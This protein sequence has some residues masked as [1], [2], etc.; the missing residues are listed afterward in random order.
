METPRKQPKK[1]VRKSVLMAANTNEQL[2]E[3]LKDVR[4]IRTKIVNR[5]KK[6]EDLNRKIKELYENYEWWKIDYDELVDNEID[7]R[8]K[9]EKVNK[10]VTKLIEN[11]DNFDH[12]DIEMA[13]ILVDYPERVG[14]E[15]YV[16][17]FDKFGEKNDG[18]IEERKVILKKIIDKEHLSNYSKEEILNVFKWCLDRE[19]ALYILTKY[20]EKFDIAELSWEGDLDFFFENINMFGQLKIEDFEN[21]MRIWDDKKCT[22]TQRII[23]KYLLDNIDKF[24]YFSEEEKKSFKDKWN[25]RT[26]S[27]FSSLSG[28]Y[29]LRQYGKK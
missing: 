28:M 3:N 18:E 5:T 2:V 21:F 14:E 9:R 7:F 17:N 1:S 13:K 10:E 12:I 6:Y 19:T 29:I 11:L 15:Y 25:R 16:H 20:F 27:R 26:K 4:S 8:H 22:W 24:D 23:W